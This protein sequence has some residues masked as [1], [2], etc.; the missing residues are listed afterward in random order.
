MSSNTVLLSLFNQTSQI[1][2]HA[3]SITIVDLV[4]V[5]IYHT[6]P[7]IRF[8]IPVLTFD[9]SYLSLKRATTCQERR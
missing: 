1:V 2:Y 4:V 9:Y 7:L 3:L 6:L 5:Q 8:S